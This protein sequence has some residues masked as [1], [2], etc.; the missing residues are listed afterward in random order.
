MVFGTDDHDIV[1]G[2]CCGPVDMLTLMTGHCSACS[3]LVGAYGDTIGAGAAILSA[4]GHADD[5]I[6]VINASLRRS[7]AL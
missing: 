1:C 4:Y 2:L 7:G 3:N 5:A 6:E